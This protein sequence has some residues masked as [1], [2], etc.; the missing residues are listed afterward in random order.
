MNIGEMRAY[1]EREI[2]KQGSASAKVLAPLFEA[3][4]DTMSEG[5]DG[6][7]ET[8]AILITEEPTQTETSS[9][10]YNV[11]S[12]Q[13]EIDEVIDTVNREHQKVK[14]SVRDNNLTILFPFVEYAND[15]A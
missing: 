8:P 13:S 15:S 11:E 12:E 7:V 14:I 10:M 6:L 2:Q 9:T 5:S 4:L 1:V 3:M